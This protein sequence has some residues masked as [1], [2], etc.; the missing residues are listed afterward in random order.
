MIAYEFNL[1]N[2]YMEPVTIDMRLCQGNSVMKTNRLSMGADCRLCGS[3]T[4]V[5]ETPDGC[6]KNTFGIC[7]LSSSN[8]KI[9]KGSILFTEIH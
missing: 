9:K 2:K 7:L 6:E 1:V 3:G 8:L 4:L 5:W